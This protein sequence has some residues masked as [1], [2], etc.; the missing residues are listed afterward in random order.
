MG[1]ARWLQETFSDLF[2]YLFKNLSGHTSKFGAPILAEREL[3][4]CKCPDF[5]GIVGTMVAA[6]VFASEQST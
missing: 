1:T 4:R 5:D 2:E 6:V 3:V